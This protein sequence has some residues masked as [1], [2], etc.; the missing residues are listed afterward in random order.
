MVE[1]LRELGRVMMVQLQPAG[2]IIESSKTPSGYLY[3]PSRLLKV[4]QLTINPLGIE[5]T[6]GAGEHMLDIH[7]INHP[8]KEYDDD[9]LVCIGFSSHYKAMRNRFG[10]HLVDGIAGENIIIEGGKEIWP[11]DLR[12][13][14]FIENAKTGYRMRLE[15][16]SHANP[17]A[18]FSQF[19]LGSPY[20]KPTANEMKA[21]LQFLGNGR[22]GFL[23][24]ME[25]GQETATVQ[26]GDKV[27]TLV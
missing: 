26:A 6:T 17:C 2:L 8:D 23:F 13:Q 9:D 11:E 10:A 14:I 20:E 7:H 19:A 24:V 16:V 4:D 12:Q 22:R 27:F 5:A 1:K 3:D 21:T 25:K 15:M 18:E